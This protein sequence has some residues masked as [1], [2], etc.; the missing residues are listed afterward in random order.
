MNTVSIEA[1]GKI[2]LGLKITGI[3]PDGFH[4]LESI[5]STIT[6]SDTITVS[7]NSNSNGISLS[8]S[9][10]FSP[11]GEAN[12]VWKTAS[13]FLEETGLTGA[14][15]ISLHKNIPSPGG[16]GEKKEPKI[17]KVGWIN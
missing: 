12:L 17:L 7:F 1:A 14:V 2:N 5:F 6:L 15:H 3:R 11:S 8:T 13:A 10:I 4:S 9:G 16:L